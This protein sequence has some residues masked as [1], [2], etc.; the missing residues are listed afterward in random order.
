MSFSG[1]K[2]NTGK[3]SFPHS[4]FYF[5]KTKA[6]APGLTSTFHYA[7]SIYFYVVLYFP[8]PSFAVFCIRSV[9]RL[10]VLYLLMANRLPISLS[11]VGM[12]LEGLP[13]G[14]WTAGDSDWTSN[15]RP[16]P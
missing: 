2:L 12:Q 11:G 3:T 4:F 9:A 16:T 10:A 7:F 13:S 6:K 5:S 14:V 15:R 8:L 1:K